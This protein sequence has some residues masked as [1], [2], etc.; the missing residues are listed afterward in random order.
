MNEKSKISHKELGN[1][2]VEQ[3]DYSYLPATPEALLTATIAPG[4]GVVDRLAR[5]FAGLEVQHALRTNDIAIGHDPRDVHDFVIELEGRVRRYLVQEEGKGKNKKTHPTKYAEFLI[6]ALQDPAALTP[7]LRRGLAESSST[8]IAEL[9]PILRD[10]QKHLHDDVAP[11]L[12]EMQSIQDIVTPEGLLSSLRVGSADQTDTYSLFGAL[13]T[14]ATRIRGFPSLDLKE[15]HLANHLLVEDP[16]ANKAAPYWKDKQRFYKQ[17]YHLDLSRPEIIRQRSSSAAS[18]LAEHAT[19]KLE[20]QIAILQLRLQAHIDATQTRE[21]QGGDAEDIKKAKRQTDED[22]TKLQIFQSEIERA[23]D[24]QTRYVELANWIWGHA[25]SMNGISEAVLADRVATLTFTW[26]DYE[27]IR[28][29]LNN[30]EYIKRDNPELYAQLLGI[31]AGGLS[32]E[33]TRSERFGNVLHI[34]FARSLH[35]A[36]TSDRPEAPAFRTRMEGLCT[37]DVRQAPLILINEKQWEFL[38]QT[39]AP[40][41]EGEE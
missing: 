17:V 18:T 34:A 33:A 26:G 4:E 12:S 27:E 41:A 10:L 19:G 21:S 31:Q 5:R 22:E 8:V 20:K 32:K 16:L 35:Q 36:A 39:L 14:L 11:H 37:L 7:T 13:H 40:Q 28:G 38:G 25:S 6:R 1:K 30:L 2:E 9:T 15:K 24:L 23:R 3:K 29:T